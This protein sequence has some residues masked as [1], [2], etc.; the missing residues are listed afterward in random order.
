MSETLVEQ[1]DQLNI[2]GNNLSFDGRVGIALSGSGHA[3]TE[4]PLHDTDYAATCL[5][6][7]SVTELIRTVEAPLPDSGVACSQ[8]EADLRRAVDRQE[9]RV[10]FQPI[11][12]L[13][14]GRIMGFEALVRWQHPTRG[15]LSPVDFLQATEESGLIVPIGLW[16]LREAS[17]QMHRWHLRFSDNP[18]LHLSVNISSKQFQQPDLVEQISQILHETGLNPTS[19]KLEITETLVMQNSESA[20]NILLQLRALNVKLAI[21]DFGTGYSSLSYLQKFPVH[22][23][24]I[25]H[26]FIS[27]LQDAKESLEIV[28][29][30]LTLAHNLGLDVIAEGIETA[31]H[32]AMLKILKCEFGQGYFYSKPVD[33]AHAEALIVKAT[34]VQ[35]AMSATDVAEEKAPEQREV[36][37]A[38][39]VCVGQYPHPASASLMQGSTELVKSVNLYFDNRDD[40]ALKEMMTLASDP[41]LWSLEAGTNP[42]EQRLK[43][44]FEI[45]IEDL[46][47]EAIQQFDQELYS[48]CLATFQFLCELEPDNRTLRDYLELCQQLVREAETEKPSALTTA[49][50]NASPIETL[51][52]S[53]Q[54]PVSTIES[55]A[56]VAFGDE[57][58]LEDGRASNNRSITD[59][60]LSPRNVDFQA[61]EGPKA[62]EEK[63]VPSISR[64]NRRF[65]LLG[66]LRK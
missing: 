18:P 27:K 65:V 36:G 24:K 4:D 20:R 15:L 11:C 47:R 17:R 49:D 32:L 14:T 59:Q 23:L 12:S 1:R 22:T 34:Q 48:V 44:E 37:N 56:A 9:F 21:D 19:L 43:E 38:S 46:K 52:K 60:D 42:D 51:G 7:S 10:F 6:K 63:E 2:S 45:H 66:R 62:R 39:E 35:F 16:V 31:N 57:S 3:G 5:V 13:D 33:M 40:K 26:S 28:R 25:D 58:G 30:V 8:V 64:N 55:N 29:A 53:G 41:A 54:S 50:S 61:E